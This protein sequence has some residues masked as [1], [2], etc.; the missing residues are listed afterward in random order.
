VAHSFFDEILREPFPDIP[1]LVTKFQRIPGLAAQVLDPSLNGLRRGSLLH[2]FES[3]VEKNVPS[4]GA[5]LHQHF[6]IEKTA[7]T[8]ATFLELNPSTQAKLD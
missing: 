3:L 8:Q 4:K 7:T 6:P 5:V 2:V 1:K